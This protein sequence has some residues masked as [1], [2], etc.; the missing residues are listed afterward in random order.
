MDPRL[1]LLQYLI[2]IA[3][4][5]NGDAVWAALFKELYRKIEKE[6]ECKPMA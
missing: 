5:P 2:S 4:K 1:N 3:D 6:T